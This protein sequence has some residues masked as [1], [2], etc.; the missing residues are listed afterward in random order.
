[1]N[2]VTEILIQRLEKKGIAPTVITGFLR[3]VMITISDNAP[4]SLQEMNKRLHVLGWDSF[5]MDDNTLQ[6]IIASLEAEGLIGA[7][8]KAVQLFKEKYE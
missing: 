6:L 1:L 5:E 3:S 2:Q 4:M 7:G 8:N